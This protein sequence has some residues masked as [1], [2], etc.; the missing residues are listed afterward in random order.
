M[1]NNELENNDYN[2][3][4]INELK[5]LEEKPVVISVTPDNPPWN[6]WV[7]FAVWMASVL[8]I[9]IFPNLIIG[10]YLVASGTTVSQPEQIQEFMNTDVTTNILKVVSIIPA[11]ILTLILSWFIVTNFNKFSFRQTLGWH[12]ASF[13]IWHAFIITVVMMILGAFLISIFGKQENELDIIVRS[14]RT[15]SYLLAIMATFTAPV[16]EEVIYRGILYSAF[17]R[18][19][20]VSIAIVLV[21]ILFAAVH[22]PQNYND[23]VAISMICLVSLILT[24]IRARTGNLLPCIALHFVFNGVQSLLIIFQPFLEKFIENPQEQSA[25]FFNLFK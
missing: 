11:H 15:A 22:I 9:I 25:L 4:L 17:Q 8:F 2:A 6:S 13:K 1:Q 14:S 10:V 16:V 3:P 21:T 24:L 5:R 7:A 12:F 20:G 23:L 18:T 19:F